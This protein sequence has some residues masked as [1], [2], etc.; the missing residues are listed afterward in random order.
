[1]IGTLIVMFMFFWI[2]SLIGGMLIGKLLWTPPAK[3]V[4]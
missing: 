4:K 3:G 1:M 2:I